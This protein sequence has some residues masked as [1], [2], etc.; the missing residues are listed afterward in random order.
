MPR[1]KY[2]NRCHNQGNLIS[3]M[4]KNVLCKYHFVKNIKFRV[5]NAIETFEFFKFG[6]KE[7]KILIPIEGGIGNQT[8]ISL[9]LDYIQKYPIFEALYI[10]FGKTQNNFSQ[11]EKSYVTKICQK[12][13]IP[14]K[15][16]EINSKYV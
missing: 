16:I 4:N 13:R 8:L 1:C 7:E 11:I 6:N 9:I 5:K 14:L 15:F 3:P 12:Y 2:F 10:D